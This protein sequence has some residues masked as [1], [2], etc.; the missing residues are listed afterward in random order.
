[1]KTNLNHGRVLQ[2]LGWIRDKLVEIEQKLDHIIY[3]MEEEDPRSPKYRKWTNGIN[4]SGWGD[5]DRDEND[6]ADQDD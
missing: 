2:Q 4:G 1:M 5:S 6:N 3:R